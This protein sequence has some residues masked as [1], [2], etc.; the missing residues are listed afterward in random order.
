MPYTLAGRAQGLVDPAAGLAR[1]TPAL[2]LGLTRIE[3]LLEALGKPH[4]SAPVVHVGG[5]NGKGSV[6]ATLAAVLGAA[7]RRVGLFVSPPLLEPRDS[8]RIDGG[9]L[10]AAEFEAALREVLP[11]AERVGASQFE[12]LTAAAFVVFRAAGVDAAVVEVGLGGDDD[13]TNVVRPEAVAITNVG[14]DHVA[15]LGPSLAAIAR[16]KAGIIKSG[17][18]VVTG[19]THA[20]VLRVFRAR[21][22]EVG[23]VVHRLGAAAPRDVSVTLSGTRFRMSSPAYGALELKTPLVGRHQALNVA[24]AVRTVELLPPRLRPDRAA[25]EAGVARVDWPGRF[26]V[27]RRRGATWVLDAAHNPGGAAALA[28]TLREVPLPRPIGGVVG[29]LADKEWRRVLAELAPA[30]DSLLLTCPG[31]PPGRQEW[32]P[33]EAERWLS[34]ST[35]RAVPALADALELQARVAEAAGGSVLVAGSTYL[36]AETLRWLQ[37]RRPP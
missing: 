9:P 37:E 16:R 35:V 10:G 29:L 12:A 33:A 2:Q 25:V 19:E 17:A 26:Q 18:P 21:A 4:L 30:V 13:A 22:R 3:A 32:S 5:T 27:V 7:R 34:R 36:V 24:L 15:E 23:A 31:A 1:L 6:A 20:G 8:V 28:A 14:R 11:A